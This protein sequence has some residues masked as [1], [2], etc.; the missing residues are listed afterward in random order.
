MKVFSVPEAL[1]AVFPATTH[2]NMHRVPALML[3][4]PACTAWNLVCPSA[5]VPARTEVQLQLCE[6]RPR[7]SF[8]CV[9]PTG[10]QFHD[11]V[12]SRRT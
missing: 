8:T 1:G 3:D 12:P 5:S 7:R 6:L 10:E 9:Q 2:A 11:P 4:A